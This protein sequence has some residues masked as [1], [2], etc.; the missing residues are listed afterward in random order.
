MLYAG[1]LCVPITS[2]PNSLIFFTQHGRVALDQLIFGLFDILI[3]NY[4]PTKSEVVQ[5]SWTLVGQHSTCMP[6][7]FC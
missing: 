2:G 7:P 5:H 1:S 6:I 4:S 3:W